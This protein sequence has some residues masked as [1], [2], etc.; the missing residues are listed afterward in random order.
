M[1]PQVQ[2]LLELLNWKNWTSF[3]GISDNAFA[4]LQTILKTNIPTGNALQEENDSP[5][6]PEMPSPLVSKSKRA[7]FSFCTISQDCSLDIT[8]VALDRAV[9]L[10]ATIRMPKTVLVVCP[11]IS[12]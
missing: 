9:H 8:T 11:D 5:Q 3:Y 10:L 7:A 4:S 1:D 2:Q 6:M 12:V